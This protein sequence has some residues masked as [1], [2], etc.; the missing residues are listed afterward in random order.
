MPGRRPLV[1]LVALFTLPL[2][3]CLHVSAQID[4]AAVKD[5]APKVATKPADTPP[6]PRL[7]FAVLPR[8]PGTLVQGTRS[9]SPAGTPAAPQ[10]TG[11]PKPFDPTTGGATV[12]SNASNIE[13]G[14]LPLAAQTNPV[15]YETPLLAAVRAHTEGNPQRAIEIIRTLNPQN[16]D[17]VLALVPVLAR[18]AT[19]DLTNDPATVAALVD[20]LRSALERLEARAALRIEKATFC[21]DVSGFGKFL[22]WPDNNAHKPNTRVQ[23]YLEVRNL[24]SQPV[25]N[26][27]VTGVQAAVEVR[28]A[29]GNLV[30][31]ID[32][33]DP[34]RRVSI[35]R[36]VKSIRTQSPLHDFHVYYEF[37]APSTPGVYTIAVELRDSNGQ[38]PVK[39][40]PM[41]FCVAGP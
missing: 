11:P 8:V 1:A 20:Q 39:T 36:Y 40:P 17:L 29:K 24:V 41:Q 5:E 3:A 33:R 27:F 10:P 19:A 7:E 18:G 12:A 14:L 22:P 26:D 2:P 23:L 31:Q 16:Q 21:S 34:K 9:A 13:P 35:V 25:G 38:R 30:E 28:D 4:P 15:A 6:P 37:P 32:E